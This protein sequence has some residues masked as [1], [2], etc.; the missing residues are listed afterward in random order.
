LARPVVALR[1]LRQIILMEHNSPRPAWRD[2]IVQGTE[3]LLQARNP[4]AISAFQRAA[5]S[6][7]D[8]PIPHLYL[9]LAWMQR[10]V[11]G[12]DSEENF[13]HARRAEEALQGALELDPD[14]WIAMVLLANLASNENRLDHARGWYRKMLLLAPRPADVWCALGAIGFRQ[15]L[16]SGKLPDR[17]DW[18]I[19]DFQ[20]AVALDPAH[21]DAMQ[22]LHFLLTE[23]ASMR[24]SDPDR[25]KDLSAAEAWLGRAADARAEKVQVQIARGSGEPAEPVEPDP[26]L[27]QWASFAIVPA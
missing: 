18:A 1:P 4:E 20:K 27:R 11:P 16:E 24:D 17:L 6:N 23:R 5:D 26:L 15:W 10:H 9:A 22:Y 13:E 3:A 12:A 21:D 14:N 7:P 2:W 25:H 19:L 8:S